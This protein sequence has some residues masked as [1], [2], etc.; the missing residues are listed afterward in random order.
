FGRQIDKALLNDLRS[1]QCSVEG[2]EAPQANPMHPFQIKLNAFLSDVAVHPMPPDT[3]PG[4]FRGM[5]KS[6]SQRVHGILRCGDAETQ[7][8]ATA[9]HKDR[10]YPAI[11]FV[12]PVCFT[13][14]A[15][16]IH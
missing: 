2:L 11:H 15:C 8:S 13:S 7:D 10:S 16:N 3:R 6:A 1:L 5:L 9:H 12:L 14:T 4:T